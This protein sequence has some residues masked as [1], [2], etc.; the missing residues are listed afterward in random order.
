MMSECGV[1][2]T[3]PV[4]P[5]TI[6]SPASHEDGRWLKGDL[7]VH[8]RHSKDSTNNSVG[9]IIDFTIG[10]GMDFLAITDHDNHVDGKIATNTWSDPEHHSDDLILLYGAEWTT[11]RGHGNTFSSAPYDHKSLYDS[12]NDRDEAIGTLKRE[13]GIHLSANHPSNRDAFSFSYDF[14][15]SIEVWNSVQYSSGTEVWDDLLKSGRMLTGRGGS[16]SH[17]GKPRKNQKQ[18][19]NSY[20]RKFNYVGTPTTWVYSDKR[21]AEALLEGL[22]SGRASISVNPYSPRVELLADLDQDGTMDLMM[23]DNAKPTTAP[24]T[25][26]VRLAG[27]SATKRTYKVRVV[28][29]GEE[30]LKLKTNKKTG[31]VQFQDAPTSEERTYY[32]VEIRGKKNK[33]PGVQWSTWL[34]RNLVGL[35]NPI[36]FNYDPDFHCSN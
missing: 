32:R 31:S 9:K 13:L 15:D 24:V 35:S 16:D 33:Y 8:S 23:G 29:N 21:N 28:K 36:Y 17:H 4:I 7:H 34:G 10:A 30:F 2:T 11:P 18:S 26:E 22:A 27:K 6:P 20:E 3:R 5:A 12:R 19:K 1:A 14:A 25:F